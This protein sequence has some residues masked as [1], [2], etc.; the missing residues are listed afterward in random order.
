MAVLVL[1]AAC[2]S[3]K[4]A[5]PAP[6][7]T[8]TSASAS[9]TTS[10]ASIAPSDALAVVIDAGVD[11][12]DDDA[13]TDAG[14]VDVPANKRIT[15]EG[16]ARITRK[17]PGK[18]AALAKLLP[19]LEWEEATEDV[20]AEPRK[21]LF[22]WLPGKQPRELAMR[23]VLAKKRIA[24]QWVYTAGYKT[25]AGI[26]IGQTG[27]QLAKAYP[28][29]SCAMTDYRPRELECY[30][31]D[32]ENVVFSLM[33]SPNMSMGDV[34]TKDVSAQEILSIGWRADD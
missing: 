16:I 21:Q 11:A 2:G 7:S 17:T 15:S 18:R 34:E 6:A 33:P 14:V 23:V 3:K 13:P 25:E 22:G 1:L 27:A 24:E 19:D 29:L 12:S 20:D 4:E 9:A 32:L 26:E 5:A 31:P 28:D 8:P 30:S 10:D